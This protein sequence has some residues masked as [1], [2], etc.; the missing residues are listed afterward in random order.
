MDRSIGKLT[1][2]Y[3]ADLIQIDLNQPHLAPFYGDYSSMTYYARASDMVTG[4]IDDRVVMENREV[5]GLDEEAAHAA[6]GRHLPEWSEL[7]SSAHPG[8]CPCGRS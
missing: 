6:L 8:L 1:E 2:G 7:V 3:K 4:V 5:L